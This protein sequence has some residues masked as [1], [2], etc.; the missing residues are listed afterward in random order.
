M[1]AWVNLGEEAALDGAIR[2]FQAGRK[3][4]A[5]AKL[6]GA[7]YAFD[8][9]CPHAFGPMHRGEIDGS[10]ITC[11]YHAW[12]FDLACA[13]REVHGYRPLATYPVKLESG[14]VYVQLEEGAEATAIESRPCK[15]SFQPA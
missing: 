11:P 15:L 10:V 3:K 9:L 14:Q 8:G 1:A 4:I 13:G 7:V 6:E 12:R 2:L 5:L